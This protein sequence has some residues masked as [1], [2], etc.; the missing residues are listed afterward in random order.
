MGIVGTA[1]T[2][3]TIISKLFM[4]YLES[5]MEKIT[6]TIDER[7]NDYVGLEERV[8]SVENYHIETRVALAKIG[9][10]IEYIKQENNKMAINI[11]KIL[12]N[13]CKK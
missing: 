2:I 6:K 3:S 4:R 9:K 1:I 7:K 12:N 11:E 13:N 8:K 10:D 5:Q